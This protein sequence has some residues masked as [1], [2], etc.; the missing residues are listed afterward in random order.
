MKKKITKL[1]ESA[2][3]RLY[4]EDG[5]LIPRLP[6]ANKIYDKIPHVE[7]LDLVPFETWIPPE[8]SGCTVYNG[9]YKFGCKYL[10]FSETYHAENPA[11]ENCPLDYG[12]SQ[13][14]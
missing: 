12:G 7:R 11:P 1:I 4:D 8:C 9:G 3:P 13:G 14:N 5:E 6:V 2:L 10:M